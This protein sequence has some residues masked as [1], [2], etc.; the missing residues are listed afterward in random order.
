M[1][2]YSAPS[3]DTGAADPVLACLLARCRRMIAAGRRP[4]FGLNGPVGAGKTTLA[5]QLQQGFAE[6]GLLLAVASIDD[7]YWPW[8]ER[9]H[10]LAGNPFGVSRVP[11]GS[12]DPDALLD[13]IE[14]W[15]S[16][17]TAPERGAA[18]LSLP[19]FD[20]R[21]RDG[22]GD[23]IADWR[24]QADAVLLEG[25]LMGCQPLPESALSAWQNFSALESTAQTWLLR[26]N[27][28]LGAYQSLWAALDGL[29][30]LWPTSW[31]S[32]RRWRLQAEARQRRA[33]GGWLNAAALDQLIRASLESLPPQLY[34]QPLLESAVWVRVLDRRRHCTW[35]GSGDA[36]RR[37]EA[38]SSSACSSA[39]G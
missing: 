15:R 32:P 39:T 3:L 7:A 6:A 22:A 17:P 21:L 24:G 20:K 9:Q 18:A 4:L 31:N 2:A 5:R 11:P 27:Q 37:R 19:R 28:A 34:Q 10:R 25:W 33:G 38:Q 8:P 36:W 12:H 35:Q 26:C 30:V 23:R 1:R 14:R 29:I 13:P 16:S